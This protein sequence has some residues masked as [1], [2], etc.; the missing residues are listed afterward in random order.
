MTVVVYVC[1]A[2][3]MATIA[4][5]WGAG[6]QMGPHP[7]PHAVPAFNFKSFSS[8]FGVCAFCLLCHPGSTLMLRGMPSKEKTKRIYA[9]CF[10]LIVVAYSVLALVVIFF[11]GSGVDAVVTM[12]WITY[13]SEHW[14][15]EKAAWVGPIIGTVIIGFPMCSITA[16]LVLYIRSLAESIEAMLP[17]ALLHKLAA[18]FGS[19]YEGRQTKVWPVAWLIRVV[20]ILIPA[21]LCLITDNFSKAMAVAGFLAF[22]L[23]YF[24]P[25]VMQVQSKRVMASIG[26][27]ATP[28]DDWS[29]HAVTAWSVFAFALAC[30]VYYVATQLIPALGG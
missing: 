12:N 22:F 25:F 27:H 10:A 11:M 26:I 5:A 18:L 15:P 17:V 23:V 8:L 28:Y 14:G 19:A 13:T 2:L 6:R 3:M 16:S 29:G 20:C 21:S 7:A 1:L 30:V 9:A 4:L 24:M